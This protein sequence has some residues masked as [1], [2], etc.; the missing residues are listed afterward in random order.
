M[1]HLVPV[2]SFNSIDP[3]IENGSIFA[4]RP[5]KHWRKQLYIKGNGS[6][7]RRSN[8]GIPTDRPGGIV[9]VSGD[10]IQC[11]VCACKGAL[12]IKETPLLYTGT[13]CNNC[14]PPRPNTQAKEKVFIDNDSYLKSRCLTYEQQ[15]STIPIDGISYFS[16][17][18]IPLDPT[19]S[20]TGPQVRDTNN[21]HVSFN[22]KSPCTNAIYKPNNTQYAQQGGVSSS[23]RLMRLKYNIS[24]NNGAA[25]LSA[26][27]AANINSGRYQNEPSPSY[28]VKYKPYQ[29]MNNL[30]R[31]TGSKTYCQEYSMSMQE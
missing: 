25:Y 24:N 9:P 5:L 8:L 26:A 2:Y 28:V 10:Q 15:L 11:C 13:L 18:G 4:A 23:S 29:C 31:K 21:C 27:G 19:N 14:R 16:A 7:N 1:N 3:G 30:S 17:Q 12:N 22:N 20:S 6:I